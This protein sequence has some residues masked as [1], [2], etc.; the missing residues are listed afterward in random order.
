[1]LTFDIAML[2]LGLVGSIVE[3]TLVVHCSQNFGLKSGY[4][5][6]TFLNFTAILKSDEDI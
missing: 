1:M 6:V 3:R 2:T 5:W 4:S